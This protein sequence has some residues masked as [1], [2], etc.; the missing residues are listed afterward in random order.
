MIVIGRYLV[1]NSQ[2]AIPC[3]E[4]ILLIEEE[5]GVCLRATITFS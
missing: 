1:D 5:R 3:A 4:I 2:V